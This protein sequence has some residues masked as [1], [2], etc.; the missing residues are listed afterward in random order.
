EEVLR[1]VALGHSNKETATQL[2]ISV[3]TVEAHKAKAMAKL[4]MKGRIDII[5]YG[6]LRGWLKEN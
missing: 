1:L 5:R 2:D 4:G 6:L 3:K